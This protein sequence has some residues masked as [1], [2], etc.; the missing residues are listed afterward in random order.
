MIEN[1]Y[2]QNKII[3]KLILKNNKDRYRMHSNNKFKDNSS[4]T[5]KMKMQLIKMTII[6]KRSISKLK[7]FSFW[8][9][10]CMI[11]WKNRLKIKARK[12]NNNLAF[13]SLLVKRLRDQYP[14]AN[15]VMSM[16]MNMTTKQIMIRQPMIKSAI[17]RHLILINKTKM[18]QIIYFQQMQKQQKVQ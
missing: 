14:K 18:V 11:Y 5:Y 2:R 9:K 8:I 10:Q 15:Q 16:Y 7:M 3:Y 17:Q 1:L 6:R 12:S 4:S 13:I